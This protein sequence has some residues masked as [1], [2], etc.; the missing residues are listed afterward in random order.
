MLME[1]S[2]KRNYDS[3]EN[4]SFIQE[5]PDAFLIIRY[6]VHPFTREPPNLHFLTVLEFSF[7]P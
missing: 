1:I 6:S 3:G 4:R 7:F 2:S 5:V